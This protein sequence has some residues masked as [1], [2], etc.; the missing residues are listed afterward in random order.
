MY[1][2]EVGK[3]YSETKKHWPEGVDYNYRKQ[4]HEL[5]LFYRTPSE[6]EIENIRRA[7]ARFALSVQGD[8]I[9]FLAKFGDEEW[10]DCGFNIHLVPKNERQLPPAKLNGKPLVTVLLIDAETG[11]LKVFRVLTFSD[12]FIRKLHAAITAQ[13]T[14]PFPAMSDY[15]AQVDNVYRR[16][17][18]RQLAMDHAIIRCRGGE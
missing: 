6:S 7:P 10:V 18:S 15:N 14:K 17:T 13:A 8:I 3:R 1:L 16:Y 4:Q 2:Y 11:I 5:R 12:E 9:F